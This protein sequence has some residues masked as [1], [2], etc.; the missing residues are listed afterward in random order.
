VEAL[1]YAL[2][3]AGT[4]LFAAIALSTFSH[5]V[6]V[7]SLL[8]FLAVG[9]FATELP[10]LQVVKV[11][12][13]T[14]VLVGNL[15]L[16]V[17]LLDG[18][19]RTRFATFRMAA[20]PALMLATLGVVL[21]ASIVGLAG[22]ALL[23]LD[24]RHGLLLG[25]I[26]GSTDAAAVF[27]LLGS[28]G[29]RLNE[30]VESTLEVESGLNDPMA[31][32]LTLGLIAL[33]QTPDQRNVDLLRMFLQQ[34]GVGVLG[35]VLLGHLLSLAV[36][37]VHLHESLYALLI[38]SGGLV[39]FSLVNLLGGS[40][41]LAIYLAGMLVAGRRKRVGEDVLRV[42]DGFAWLA[43]AGMFLVLGIIT[44]ARGLLAV[45]GQAL[46]VASVLMFVARPVAVALCLLPFRF[47]T[48]EIAF[49]GWIGLRGAVPIVLGLFPLLAGVPQSP[50]LFHVAFFIVLLSLLLQGS[51]LPLA[52][53]LASVIA[54]R[55]RAAIAAASLE[56]GTGAREVLQFVVA[57]RAPATRRPFTELPWPDGVR[58]IDIERDGSLVQTTVLRGGDIVAVVAPTVQVGALEELFGPVTA[59]SEMTLDAAATLGDLEDYYGV[60]V[61]AG[62]TRETTVGR[63]A[64]LLLR[65]RAASGDII[66]LGALSLRV[67]ESSAGRVRSLS[68][69]FARH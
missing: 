54:W 64:E 33:I 6:G 35:G 46:I 57:D 34:M 69:Q 58:V 31:V 26:V 11:G 45:A 43:Q 3:I 32:F 19:L 25:A 62:W 48:R 30:R 15:A 13:D 2:L 47:P 60:T 55:P 41:F 53:R 5:R 4:L 23:D 40:G 17:I 49:I 27:A 28:S 10:G 68:M 67:R 50:L 24:W 12:L 44:D 22:A 36:A 29:V 1:N 63:Y 61:P 20:R 9:L 56:G 18:G 14:A 8:V 66:R 65:G 59:E 38:Q 51:S 7:P 21:T 52:A 37:R 39:I 16:A 42:S